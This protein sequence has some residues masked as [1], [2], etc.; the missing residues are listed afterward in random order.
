MQQLEALCCDVT[1]LSATTTA[2][3]VYLAALK[4]PIAVI[5]D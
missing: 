3:K 1:L 5:V 4:R 2:I